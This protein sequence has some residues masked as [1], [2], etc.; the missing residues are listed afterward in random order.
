MTLRLKHVGVECCTAER[1]SLLSQY[2]TAKLQTGDDPVQ[3][4]H[5][6]VAESVFR[7]WL[8]RFLPKRFGVTKGYIIT[9]DLD[10]DAPLEEWDI[11]IY[12]HLESPVLFVR[13]TSGSQGL[14]GRRAIPV[15]HVRGVLEVKA[16]LNPAMA[17]KVYAKLAGLKSH[18]GIDDSADYP[19]YLSPPFVC[20]GIFFETKVSSRDEYRRS[21][22][23]LAP[24]GDSG[25]P[26][27]GFLVLR[28]QTTPDHCAHL[29]FVRSATPLDWP[30]TF[31]MSSG[32]RCEDGGY[33]CLGS[34]IGWGANHFYPYLFRL[35]NCLRGVHRAGVPS[36]YGI[37]YKNNEGSRLFSNCKG[38]SSS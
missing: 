3:V 29:S 25:L 10:Y 30:D 19:K 18:V 36:F 21:L 24:L 37:D 23:V 15:E 35:L 22:D 9:H 31:E 13:D 14:D 32:H 5:G 17:K 1:V 27:I 33:E 6:H 7:E 8:G 12:D 28:S 4:D 20:G 16:T 2:D 38:T 34:L 26:C 11:I